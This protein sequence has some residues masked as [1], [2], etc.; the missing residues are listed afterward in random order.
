[1]RS[2]EGANICTS[3]KDKKKKNQNKP[4]MVLCYL[5][6][7]HQLLQSQAHSKMEGRHWQRGRV[8]VEVVNGGVTDE[9]EKIATLTVNLNN[10]DFY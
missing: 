3:K 1:M 6:S 8:E 5:L 4:G 9:N 10:N 7:Y 2:R